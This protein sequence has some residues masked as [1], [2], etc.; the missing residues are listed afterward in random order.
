MIFWPFLLVFPKKP[1]GSFRSAGESHVGA[2]AN[3]G[4]RPARSF[5]GTACTESGKRENPETPSHRI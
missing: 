3:L 2:R 4:M 5:R 1:I